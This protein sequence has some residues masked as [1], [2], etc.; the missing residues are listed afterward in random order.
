MPEA[1]NE[2]IGIVGTGNVAWHIVRLFQAAGVMVSGVLVRNAD[3]SRRSSLGQRF[4]VPLTDDLN[5]LS[6][7]SD[8]MII[9]VNDTA[10]PE[11]AVNLSDYRGIVCHTSGSC[12]I[13]LLRQHAARAGVFYP[14]QTLS[15]GHP[16]PPN[17]IPIC[18][19]GSDPQVVK[20][21]KSLAGTIGCPS[22]EVSSKERG[23]LHVAAVF[24]CNFTNHMLAIAHDVVISNNMDTSLIHPLIRET[25]QKA[26]GGD[27]A[28]VQT[29]PAVRK[30]IDTI[31][32]HLELLREQPGLKM[33]YETLT[34]SIIEKQNIKKT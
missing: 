10:I 5:A 27:P 6:A 23:L 22:I 34:N 19:E 33:L 12:H 4:K 11:I 21:L 26:L 20:R 28:D 32:K 29:G 2:R 1:F 9:A 3:K 13:N 30:D 24:A 25:M 8:I 14:L 7:S 15:T 31:S 18:V 17:E 16:L